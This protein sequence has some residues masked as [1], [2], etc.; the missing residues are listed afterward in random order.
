MEVKT[1]AL[2]TVSVPDE[3]L[4]VI[5]H[6]LFGFEEYTQYVLLPS[7]YEPFL[8]LQSVQKDSLAFLVVDPFLVCSDYEVD[9]DDKQL[10]EIGVVSPSDVAV[11][12][13]VT[14][15]QKQGD[16]TVNLQGP[17]IINTSSN[18]CMQAILSDSRWRIK[19]V[20][21]HPVTGTRREIC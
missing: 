10:E 15:P 14:L 2:G 18:L 12:A 7:G 4:L 9:I 6:G 8:W 11:M 5:P 1:K 21:S 17:L 13:L 3:Q 19:H 20:I 16:I